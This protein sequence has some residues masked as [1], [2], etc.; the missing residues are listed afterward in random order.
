M[1]P[2]IREVEN[3]EI[4][5]TGEPGEANSNMFLSFDIND[6]PGVPHGASSAYLDIGSD[7]FGRIVVSFE[8][9]SSME[10]VAFVRCPPGVVE[11]VRQFKSLGVAGLP[12]D[13]E[14]IAFLASVRLS[15][16]VQDS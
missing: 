4:S 13:G 16:Q 2:A 15:C 12:A 11:L 8:D 6:V 5:I 14:E 7:G 10:D 3:Y 9:S 1:P